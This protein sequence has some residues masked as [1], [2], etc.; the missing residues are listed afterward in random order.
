M[1]LLDFC[2]FCKRGSVD[3]K[4]IG[5]PMV[6]KTKGAPKARK[7]VYKKRRCSTCNMM[8]HTKRNCP[9]VKD[10]E[11]EHSDDDMS[12]GIGSNGRADVDLKQENEVKKK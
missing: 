6:A 10:P 3:D 8:G 12:N 9:T 7:D 5:D 4:N 2:L 11:L 1:V